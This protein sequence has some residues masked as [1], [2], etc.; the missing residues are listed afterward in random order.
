MR[1]YPYKKY[2]LLVGVLFLLLSLPP[3]MMRSV[4]GR[5]FAFFFPAMK[6][7]CA[8]IKDSQS[9]RLEAENH[10]LRIEIGKLRALLE[11]SIPDDLFPAKAVAAHVIYRDPGTWTSSVWIDVGEATDPIIRKNSPVVVGRALVGVIDYVGKQQSRVRLITDVGLKP[12]V[13]AVRGAAQ[14]RALVE[15][16]IPVLRHLSG[17]KDL[18]ISRE[19][20]MALGRML[21]QFKERLSEDCAEWY[22]AK[23]ILQGSGTPL[24]RSVNQSLRG[25]GFNYDFPDAFGPARELETGKPIDPKSTMPA[26][27]L[28]KVNDL[29]VTTGLDGVFPPGLSVGE[30]TK[31]HPLREG[32]YTYEIEALPVAGDLDSLQTL[33]VIPPVGYDEEDQPR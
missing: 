12:A 5:V 23:G 29:L 10:L 33:F 3:L 30:V 20:Q 25:I 11:H 15:H 19:D 4:R 18:P 2:L 8:G 9:E 26:L 28:I 17:R 32:A 13:R 22:L 1:R 14:N 16:I 7:A 27:P 21:T 6:A 24:W 31:I